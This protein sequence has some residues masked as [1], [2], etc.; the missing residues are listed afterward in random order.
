VFRELGRGLSLAI[1]YGHKSG[2]DLSAGPD[3]GG[4]I[5][6]ETAARWPTAQRAGARARKRTDARVVLLDEFLTGTRWTTNGLVGRDRKAP[7]RRVA[8]CGSYRFRRQIWD[9]QASVG[10]APPAP[11]S[12]VASERAARARPQRSHPMRADV[13]NTNPSRKPLRGDGIGRC[14]NRLRPSPPNLQHLVAN[15]GRFAH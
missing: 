9:L 3:V 1:A 10:R 13:A 6:Q 7:D 2:D 12:R 14:R 11:A 4:S 8:G 15:R 5:S